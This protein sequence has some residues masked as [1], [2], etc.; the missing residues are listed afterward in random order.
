MSGVPSLQA[1]LL[2]VLNGNPKGYRILVRASE[3]ALRGVGAPASTRADAE[4][5]VQDFLHG[6]L[7]GRSAAADWA[8]LPPEA[9]EKKLRRSLRN[10]AIDAL[11]AWRE[12][13][14]LREL[15]RAV[16]E[17]PLPAAAPRPH[18][19]FRGGRLHRPSVAD[20]C[21]WILTDSMAPRDARALAAALAREWLVTPAAAQLIDSVTGSHAGGHDDVQRAA[22]ARAFLRSTSKLPASELAVLRAARAPTLTEGARRLGVAL[23]TF[24]DRLKRATRTLG[25]AVRRLKL[26]PDAALDGLDAL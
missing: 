1:A 8:A 16:L 22:D 25:D 26:E 18:S 12:L 11:P 6:V 10:L 15:I 13:K 2:S 21:A 23:S 3:T 24:A 5:L 19:L 14:A 4:D 17:S 9:C 7:S 20:A